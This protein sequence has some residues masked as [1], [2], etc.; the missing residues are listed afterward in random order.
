MWTRIVLHLLATCIVVAGLIGT[1]NFFVDRESRL[2]E[3]QSAAFI[4]LGPPLLAI[5][6]VMLYVIWSPDS[7]VSTGR[8]L[9]TG[10]AATTLGM[11]A[12]F[13]VLNL[14]GAIAFIAFRPSDEGVDT[15]LFYLS[16]LLYP[17]VGVV[18]GILTV[19]RAK[20]RSNFDKVTKGDA[21]M[22]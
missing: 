2:F 9:L 16:L 1:Y 12:A 15:M 14:L 11:I 18:V 21:S 4:F 3:P 10:V 19:R 8:L 7:R 13:L 6:L 5:G 17:F 20:R 22:N